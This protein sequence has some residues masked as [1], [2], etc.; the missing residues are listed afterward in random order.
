MIKTARTEVLIPLNQKN[1]N[2]RIYHDNENLREKIDE[3]NKRVNEIGV[4]YGELGYPENF[5]TTLRNVSHCIRNVRIE[6]DKVVGDVIPLDTRCGKIFKEHLDE[7]VVR[8]RAA[9]SI[10]H[11]GTVN[12]KKLFT[13]DVIRKEED[14]FNM[15]NGNKEVLL[16]ERIYSELDP[17]GE[18]KWEE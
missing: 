3:F 12:I 4:V 1:L 11:D 16:H 15:E 7:M 8:P 10:N 17:Y 2:G 9:G 13:F 6:G 14:A 18:E 5:D